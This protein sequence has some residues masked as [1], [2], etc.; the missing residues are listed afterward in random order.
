M[1]ISIKKIW[2]GIKTPYAATFF[3]LITFGVMLYMVNAYFANAQ[4]MAV[5]QMAEYQPSIISTIIQQIGSIFFFPSTPTL[6]LTEI[7]MVATPEDTL[8][9]TQGLFLLP[10]M[11]IAFFSLSPLVWSLPIWGLIYFVKKQK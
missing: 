6:L 10:L 11:F 4:M 7:S 5:I 9:N 3:A 8:I 1:T 2:Q